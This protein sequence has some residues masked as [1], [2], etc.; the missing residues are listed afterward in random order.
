MSGALLFRPILPVDETRYL[1]VAWEMWLR[2]DYLVPHL[3]GATYSHKPPLL[4]WLINAGWSVFGVTDWWPRLVAPAFGLGCLY[5][6]AR[7]G[8]RLWP[9]HPIYLMA[10]FLLVGTYYW[11]IYT[12]LTM[13]DLIMCFWV[14]LGLH[15]LLDVL[16]DRGIR[17]WCLFAFALGMGVLS[18][19]PVT[20][21]YLL[22]AALFAP[23]WCATAINAMRW[24]AGLTLATVAGAALALGWAIPAGFSGGE[25]YRNA[26]FW[27]QSA[28]RV[29][30]SFAHGK[31]F[32]WYIA[33]LPGLVLPWLLW[34]TLWKNAW[35]KA[36]SFLTADTSMAR[37]PDRGIRLSLIWS[38]TTIVILS[39]ISGKRPHYLLPIFPALALLVSYLIVMHAQGSS[40]RGRLDVLPFTLVSLLL[41]TALLFAPEIAAATDKSMWIGSTTRFWSGPLFLIALAL[42]WRPPQEGLNRLLSIAATSAAAIWIIHAVASPALNRAYD[43]RPVAAYVA[44]QQKQGIAVANFGKY[45]GQYNFLG[46]LTEPVAVTGQGDVVNWLEDHP[47]AKIVSYYDKFEP[48]DKPAF[49]HPF[50][51]KTIAVWDRR[52]ILAYPL[53][54]TRNS[55]GR[56]LPAKK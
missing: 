19:G 21:V 38:V 29:V 30:E 12:T 34:P 46:R 55:A 17:G 27:G 50:R 7:L 40:I 47:K 45:H 18:K 44:V 14:L 48:Q 16:K 54:A 39:A 25:E 26:I 22:P 5:L 56:R 31:P 51:S 43:M 33:V 41:A 11:A 28:G 36:Q 2:D 32:W 8:K 6:T 10:P 4:F 13:F 24:Y 15:S 9:D 3:N 52:T 37:A 23:Y 42:L 20:I 1:S 53:V 35:Q 49:T